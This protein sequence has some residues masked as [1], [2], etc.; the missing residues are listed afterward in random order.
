[1]RRPCA[2]ICVLLFAAASIS[3]LATSI[4]TSDLD[5]CQSDLDGLRRIAADASED[6]RAKSK[7]L[8][9]CRENPD[10]YD[11][12]HDGCR[13]RRSDYESALGDLES[14]MDDLDTRLHSVQSSCR[15]DF[16]LNKLSGPEAAQRSLCK[17]Y[18]RF[19]GL[20]INAK[21]CGRAVRFHSGSWPRL[22]A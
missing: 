18:R 2:L 16:T 17:S 22:T 15:Y 5:S 14:K 8:D 19:I 12:F 20:G 13:N 1:M 3:L 10:V 6:A 11:L 7:D 4:S 9:E 21:K